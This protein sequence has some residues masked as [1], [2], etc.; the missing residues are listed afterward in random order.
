MAH[1]IIIIL[2]IGGFTGWMLFAFTLY[3][4]LFTRKTEITM[5]DN[6]M[7]DIQVIK[8]EIKELK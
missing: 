2:F 7:E 3:R 4:L 1:Y 8:E 6:I 5:I